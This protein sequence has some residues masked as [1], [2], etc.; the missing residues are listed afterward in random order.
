MGGGPRTRG[1]LCR[2]GPLL[3]PLRFPLPLRGLEPIE[4]RHRCPSSVA[5]YKPLTAMENLCPGPA[6]SLT[7]LL[8]ADVESEKTV[9]R[10]SRAFRAR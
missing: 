5:L 4:W 2:L 3:Q 9:Y 6:S 8:I 1:L 10:F 7:A